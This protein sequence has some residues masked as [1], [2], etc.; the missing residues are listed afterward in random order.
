MAD[1][2]NRSIG[3]ALGTNSVSMAVVQNHPGDHPELIAFESQ[4]CRYLR[5]GLIV[6]LEALTN[7]IGKCRH[8]I[9]SLVKSNFQ[10][11]TVNLCGVQLRNEHGTTT[12]ELK[13]KKEINR[14]HLQ[15]IHQVRLIE[16]DSE[17]MLLHN[18]P[19][20]YA[21]NNQSSLMSPIGMV[22]Q[23]LSAEVQQMYAPRS[24][25]ENLLYALGKS[26]LSVANIV[27]DPLSSAEALIT[28]DERELGICILDIG[29]SVPDDRS[30]FLH[31]CF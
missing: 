6:N 25:I 14:K 23:E 20:S 11:V 19:E 16:D 28:D 7:A 9:Q 26:K 10:T 5:D 3:L 12:F 15:Q 17:W 1:A 27:A 31:P 2:R 18:F 24:A 22:G 8:N 30:V 13:R 21:L 4:K 29:G